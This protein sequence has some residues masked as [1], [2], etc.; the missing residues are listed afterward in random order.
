MSQDANYIPALRFKV[1]TPFYDPLLRWGMRE[2]TFKNRLIEEARI[3]PGYRVLDLGCGTGTLTILVK[4]RQPAAEVIG[5]DG[6]PQVLEIARAKAAQQNVNITLDQ[7]MAYQLPYPNESFD[8]VISSLVLH[9]LTTTDRQRALR[10]V[11]RVLRQG[12]EFWI[13]DFGKPHNPLAFVISLVMRNLE[14]TQD[15]IQGLLPAQLRGAG[16][17][18]VAEV[19]RFMTL[20]GTIVLYRARKMET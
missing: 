6:D 15:L 11:F 1:L 9:H 13:V 14:R 2:E 18:E 5:F 7:G 12:G 16:F 20:F 10:E 8:R 4:Q 17:Q 3:T 19:A